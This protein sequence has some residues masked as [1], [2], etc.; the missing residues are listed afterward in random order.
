MIVSLI[1][2]LLVMGTIF[3]FVEKRNVENIF[4]TFII[5]DILYVLYLMFFYLWK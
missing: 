3:G 4:V 1:I 5:L 2:M